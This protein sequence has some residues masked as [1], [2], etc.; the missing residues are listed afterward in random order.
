MP[1][2]LRS[3]TRSITPIMNRIRVLIFVLVPW[4]TCIAVALASLGCRSM[5]V[6]L[7]LGAKLDT[8]GKAVPAA[9]DFR[10]Y[11]LDGKR[12]VECEV[13]YQSLD[14]SVIGGEFGHLCSHD[15]YGE[16]P[17]DVKTPQP[18][19][20]VLALDDD[21]VIA[22]EHFDYARAIRIDRPEDK[23]HDVPEQ[24]LTHYRPLSGDLA[25]LMVF[26]NP[27]AFVPDVRTAGNYARTPLV[28]LVSYGVDVPVT[29]VSN[30]GLYTLFGVAVLIDTALQVK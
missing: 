25:E 11:R 17:A 7:N 13:R 19:R 20:Y 3:F 22:T 27:V 28:A 1:R 10:Y 26:D 8:I 21:E 9:H 4:I 5:Y 2:T 29:L 16:L 24:Y 18:M 15:E 23:G 12:Y 6:S 14:V 30:I